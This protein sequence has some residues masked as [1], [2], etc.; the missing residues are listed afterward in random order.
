MKKK[1]TQDQLKEQLSYDPYTGIFRWKISRV[2]VRAGSIAGSGKAG[3][4]R[5]IGLHK[6]LYL[7]HRL[8]WLY[9][10]GVMPELD[11][12]DHRDGNRGNNVFKNLR[13]VTQ[14]LNVHNQRRKRKGSIHSRHIGV[15][16]HCRDNLWR[17]RIKLGK[18][19]VILGY[20]KTEELARVAYLEAKAK[21]HA[22][23]IAEEDLA[24]A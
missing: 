21:H 16:F 17:A 7:A 3:Q 10:T 13:D 15:G 19:R 18:K 4:Y 24:E 6:E 12:I 1:I 14:Q 9:M 23:Y 22:G 11:G 8:A 5:R 2:G 20:F